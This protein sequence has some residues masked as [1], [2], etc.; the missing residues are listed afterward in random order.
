MKNKISDAINKIFINQN[1]STCI[2]FRTITKSIAA[3]RQTY[4]FMLSIFSLKL[5]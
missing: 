5:Q 1:V 3:L 4:K 2:F